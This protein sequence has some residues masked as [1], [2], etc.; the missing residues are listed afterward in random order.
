MASPRKKRGFTLVELVVTIGIIAALAAI[1]YPTVIRQ[2]DSADPARLAE[3]L[4]NIRTGIET[5][6]VNVRPHQPRDIE[7][8][9]NRPETGDVHALGVAYSLPSDSSRW[10]GPYIGAAV[11]PGAL[12]GE[13]VINTGYGASI[14]NTLPL[15]DI[16]AGSLTGGDTVAVTGSTA[17]ADFIAIMVT[18]LSGTAFNAVNLLIDGPTEN[19]PVLRRSNGR[20]RCPYAGAAPANNAACPAAYFLATPVRQ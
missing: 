19:D 5:F 3:D 15:Y 10:L 16:N 1:I 14:I 20:F 8:L 9:I 13:A 12:P 7:D 4:S 2:F 18:G 11:L 6:S 17:G